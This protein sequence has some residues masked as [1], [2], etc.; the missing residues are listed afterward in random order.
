MLVWR[1]SRRGC[2]RGPLTVRA[3]VHAP[4]HASNS[5]R[6]RCALNKHCRGEMR[7]ATH[8]LL[9]VGPT[10]SAAS[11]GVAWPVAPASIGRGAEPLRTATHG[12]T[13]K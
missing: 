10:G 1:G 11:G 6:G 13:R 12:A 2:M 3:A 4:R 8:E 5:E 7:W 9:S